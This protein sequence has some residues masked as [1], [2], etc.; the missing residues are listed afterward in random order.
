[1]TTIRDAAL[2]VKDVATELQ[3]SGTHVLNL[4]H[5]KVTGVPVLPHVKTGLLYRIRRASFERWMEEC[6]TREAA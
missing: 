4:L 2:T 3:C 5:G 6:E 1:M